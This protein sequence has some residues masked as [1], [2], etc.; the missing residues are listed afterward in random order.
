MEPITKNLDLVYRDTQER[1]RARATVIICDGNQG[2]GK[3][4]FGVNC[5]DYL[6]AKKGLPPVKLETKD[7]P[8]VSQGY[9]Q[10][11]LNL[12]R[13]QKEG[14]PFCM[15]DEAGDFSKKGFNSRANTKLYEI[16]QKIRNT[17]VVIF[18]V[19]PKFYSLDNTL[20]E[21][22]IVKFLLHLKF[23]E[24][25]DSLTRVTGYA[26]GTEDFPASF[27]YLRY[28]ASKLSQEYKNQV[29][30][31]VVPDLATYCR[32]GLSPERE[33]ALN[34]LSD[35]GKSRERIALGIKAQ[36]LISTNELRQMLGVNL[37]QFLY[38]K[39]KYNISPNQ[40]IG[41]T[42]Y[43]TKEYAQELYKKINK[44]RK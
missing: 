7:H 14:L 42:N 30:S 32:V 3:T 24:H 12:E 35:K 6:N 22:G 33:K 29:Y 38:L 2:T 16:F 10:F 4:T 19:L 20:Y 28:K 40:K 25:D 43:F 26:E 21:L 36:G 44:S 31:N 17:R 41:V 37:N 23:H 5:G 18:M 27:N 34:A 11:A 1:K 8:Q 39:G 13:C 9:K 15:Y